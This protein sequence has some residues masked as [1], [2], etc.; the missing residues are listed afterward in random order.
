MQVGHVCVLTSSARISRFGQHRRGVVA[1][2]WFEYAEPVR[3]RHGIGCRARL[4]IRA[5]RA[6]FI[7]DGG[8]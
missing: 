3:R 8:G 5:T 6:A 4:W 1:S 2:D 7:V